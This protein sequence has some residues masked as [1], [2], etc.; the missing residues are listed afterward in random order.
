MWWKRNNTYATRKQKN[1]HG[2]VKRVGETERW[3]DTREENK[4]K[5]VLTCHNEVYFF[6]NKN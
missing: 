1:Y 6:Q 4:K 3:G 2:M 5:S